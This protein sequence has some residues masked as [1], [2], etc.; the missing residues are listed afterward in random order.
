M[1]QEPNISGILS[2]VS[3]SDFIIIDIVNAS[4]L[5]LYRQH[6][7][8]LLYAIVTAVYQIRFDTENFYIAFLLSRHGNM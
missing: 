3:L 6:I 5:I 4:R 8:V 1:R 7:Y 2:C